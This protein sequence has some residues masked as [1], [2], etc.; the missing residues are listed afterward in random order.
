MI[1]LL[2]YIHCHQLFPRSQSPDSFVIPTN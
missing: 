1:E 2:C